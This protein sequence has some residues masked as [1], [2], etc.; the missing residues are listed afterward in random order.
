MLIFLGKLEKNNHICY[1]IKDIYVVKQ[2]VYNKIF[3]TKVLGI[4][5]N[6]YEECP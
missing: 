1:E 3:A 4:I 5:E 2:N 6:D